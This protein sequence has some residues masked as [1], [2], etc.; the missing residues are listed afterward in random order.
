VVRLV[1][2]KSRFVVKLRIV[3]RS[4]PGQDRS[5]VVR[6]LERPLVGEDVP[7]GDQD[8]AGDGGLGGVGL[9]VAALD[10]GVE[11]VAGV[12][13]SLGL[14]GF[15]HGGP[16][17]RVAVASRQ[18]PVSLS[19]ADGTIALGGVISTDRTSSAGDA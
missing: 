9:A 4:L 2:V 8:L 13:G 3:G 19:C 7:D 5:R 1:Q 14:L 6:W 17:Q 16:T 11:L 15:L 12:V 10:V 18:P